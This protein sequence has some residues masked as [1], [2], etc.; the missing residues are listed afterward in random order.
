LDFGKLMKVALLI[1]A[2][3]VEMAFG[4]GRMGAR[5]DQ[6]VQ[7]GEALQQIRRAPRQQ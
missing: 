6:F 2:C 7:L 4:I 5:P 3:I 1:D